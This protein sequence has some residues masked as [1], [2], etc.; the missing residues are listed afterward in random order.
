MSLW[1]IIVAGGSG[2]RMGSNLPKQFLLLNELPVLMHTIERFAFA[3]PDCRIVVALPES[4]IG[5][6]KS[7]CSQLDFDLEHEVVKGGATRFESVKNALGVCDDT[8]WAA[9]HDGA[10]PLV[11]EALIAKCMSK[12]QQCGNAIPVI[13]STSSLRI[14][15]EGGSKPLDR[16]KV[17]E[18]QTPQC[19]SLAT[20][21]K[22]YDQA[23]HNNFSDDASV[24]EL[25]G[26]SLHLVEGEPTNI[27]ITTQPDLKIAEAI[28]RSSQVR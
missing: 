6:W 17:V 23:P 10:R 21:K 14:V 8:G 11:S 4:H 1:A 3:L 25:A 20:L 22:A 13:K 18:V 12:A 2:S 27:K 15:D 5:L 26:E 9:V 7:M 19:F 28:L 16:S 24:V